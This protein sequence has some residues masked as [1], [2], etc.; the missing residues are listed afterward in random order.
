MQD[1]PKAVWSILY[2][3]VAFF[4][5][6]QRNFI[7]QHSSKVS[8]RPDCFFEIHHVGQS[9]FSRVYSNCCCS[10]SFE[11]EII[12]IGQSSHKLYSNN[13]LNFQMSTP[14]LNACRKL[15]WKLIEYT[16]YYQWP[17][18]S[19]LQWLL[20]VVFVGN[21]IVNPSSN[22][23][24][25]CFHITS[26]SCFWTGMNPSDFASAR[27]VSLVIDKE[28]WIRKMNIQYSH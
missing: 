22:L 7:A 2:I 25:G 13:I 26:R 19:P 12:K 27:L 1:A 17:N 14:I 6:L 20:L 9:D 4:P 8:S 5:S 15:A 3:S 10:C 23:G 24:L 11:P 21:G 28:C 18:S 16:T